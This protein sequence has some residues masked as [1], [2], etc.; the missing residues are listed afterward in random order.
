MFL[1]YAWR[2]EPEGDDPLQ[3][4]ISEEEVESTREAL[5]VLHGRAPTED[6][7]LATIEPRIRDE[8]LYRE[9]IALGLD[10][11][12]SLVRARLTE[13]M[14]FLTQDVAEP[15][16][17]TAEELEAF[18]AADPGRFRVPASISFEQRFFSSSPQRPDLEAEV[19]DAIAALQAGTAD[20]VESD[21]YLF[22]D[23][24]E[25]VSHASLAE[26][27]GAGF[28]DALA[29]LPADGV[30]QGPIRSD[31]GLHAVRVI[32]RVAAY[33]PDLDEIRAEVTS[34]L[35]AER[36]RQANETEYQKLRARYRI[37][38]GAPG[39]ADSAE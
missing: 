26:G 15:A 24:Y 22:D 37:L 32:E 11:D 28:A 33:Q 38:V 23:V 16:T 5:T 34:A 6:E 17:P 20:A 27:F 12:D 14:L 18:F 25:R 4:V 35:V 30:W 36:R 39:P 21:D 19:A 10:Q 8:I 2:G 1:L 29:A 13:K 7:L 9:A 3:I 31:F